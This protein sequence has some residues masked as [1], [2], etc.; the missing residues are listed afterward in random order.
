MRYVL[1]T[2]FIVAT[3]AAAR[4]DSFG[5]FSADE[6]M[7]LVGRDKICAPLSGTSPTGLPACSHADA[8]RVSEL[9]FRSGSKQ[10]GKSAKYEAA[11]RG[12]A[13]T[14][15]PIGGGNVVVTWAAMD[16]IARVVAVYL[17]PREQLLAVEYESRFGGGAGIEVVV[18]VLA[19][20]QAPVQT[21][22]PPAGGSSIGKTPPVAAVSQAP[23]ES[24]ENKELAAALARA[25]TLGKKGP[26]KTAEAAYREVLTLEADNVEARYGL[27]LAL[28][29][30]RK[31]APAIREL[32]VL[33]ASTRADAVIWRVEARFD[34]GFARL[35]GDAAFRAAVGLDARAGTATRLYERLVGFSS[36]WEQPEITCEQA[37]INLDMERLARTFTLRVR[38]R[39]GGFADDT[40]VRGRWALAGD[41]HVVLTMTNKQGPDDE[42]TCVMKSCSGEDCLHCGVDTDLSFMLQVVRR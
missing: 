16:P 40:R 28:A 8:G 36:R 12:S 32:E 2:A 30:Q 6:T 13:L 3:G 7:Y 26:A 17:S 23:P 14:V 1:I 31:P 11:A 27:A 4:A 22:T 9:R 5:G 24:P 38:S 10:L 34:K 21:A 37:R 29:R 42:V 41:G 35:R 20:A 39:C 18:F 33:A 19:S 15:S 25:R